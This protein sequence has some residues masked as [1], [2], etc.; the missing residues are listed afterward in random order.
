ME[1]V[2]AREVP[3]VVGS[4]SADDQ[5]SDLSF[6]SWAGIVVAFSSSSLPDQGHRIVGL[7]GVRYDGCLLI[8]EMRRE[9]PKLRMAEIL[10]TQYHVIGG[11]SGEARACTAAIR[12]LQ[13]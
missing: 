3:R 2:K 9:P 5:S 7:A 11:P 13:F 1:T 12:V 10:E 6:A 8:V 4:V